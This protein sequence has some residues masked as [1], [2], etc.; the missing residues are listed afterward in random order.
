MEM[1]KDGQLTSD[2]LE[3]VLKLLNNFN[4]SGKI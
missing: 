2:Q 4:S 3:V 1:E